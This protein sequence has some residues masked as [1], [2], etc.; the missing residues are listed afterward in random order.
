MRVS[1]GHTNAGA[2]SVVVRVGR[3]V[4]AGVLLVLGRAARGLV[5]LGPARV[6]RPRV[7][8]ALP[9]S[10][11]YAVLSRKLNITYKQA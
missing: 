4:G 9:T 10:Y 7:A 3:A 8:S 5:V 2:G 6:H 11:H 1:S